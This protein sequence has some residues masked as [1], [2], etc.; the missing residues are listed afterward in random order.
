MVWALPILVA[1]SP[2]AQYVLDTAAADLNGRLSADQISLGWFSPVRL[3]GVALKDPQGQRILD[4]SKAESSSS[5]LSLLMNPSSLGRLRVERPNL[6]LVLRPDGSNLEDL[7]AKL[8]S[9]G[10]SSTDVGIE[11]V[12]GTVSVLDTATQRQ[13]QIS[14]FQGVVTLPG[15]AQKPCEVT[16]SGTIDESGHASRFQVDLEMRQS[17][18]QRSD[19]PLPPHTLKVTTESLPLEMF[20]SVLGRVLS[21][22]I[23]LAGRLTSSVEGTWDGASQGMPFQFRGNV[24]AEQLRLATAAL[25]TDEVQLA[26]LVANG[27]VGWQ[28]GRLQVEQ[29]SAQTDVGSLQASGALALGDSTG[30]LLASLPQQTFQI[31]GQLDLARLAAMLPQTLSIQKDTQIRSGVLRLSLASRR[32]SQGMRWQGRLES[33]RLQAT[34]GGRSVEWE[35]PIRLSFNAHQTSQGPVVEDLTCESSF[36]KANG[37]GT[38]DRL[39]TKA[40]VDLGRL[41]EELRGLV[42]LGDLRMAGDGWAQL[43]WNRTPQQAFHADG[44]LQLR[45]FEFTLPNRPAWKEDSLN[46]WLVATGKTDFTVD[47]RLETAMVRV[48]SGADQLLVNLAQPMANL[49]DGGLWPVGVRAQGQLER[50][51]PRLAPWVNLSDWQFAGSHQLAAD[52]VGSA[53]AVQVQRAQVLLEQLSVAGPGIRILEPRVELTASGTWNRSDE[54]I[55]LPQVALACQSLSAQV[56][57]ATI[58]LP[59]QGAVQMA[60]VVHF[61]GDLDRIQQWITAAQTTPV[62]WRLA[63]QLSGD[64]DLHQS[65]GKTTGNLEAMVYNLAVAH[66]SGQTFQQPAIRIS[67]RADYEPSRGTVHLER[68]E[69]T[70][71]MAKLELAGDIAAAKQTRLDL[72]GQL[73]YDL[74]QISG[75]L[76]ALV[77]SSIRISG[78]GS[79]PI[80]YH[81]PLDL[82][83][84]EGS[85]ALGWTS[86]DVYGFRVGPGTL[87][88]SLGGG[89]VNF[90]PLELDVSEGK[91]RLTP[92]IQFTPEASILSVQSGRLAE[93]VRINAEMCVN[94]LQYIAPALAGVASA[95]GR[96][97]IDLDRL[98]VPLEEPSRGQ[99]AGRMMIHSVQIG[100][101]PLIQE[102]ALAMGYNGPAQLARESTIDFQMVDGRV[103]HRQLELVFPDV[104]VRTQGSVGFDKSLALMAEMPIPRKWQGNNPLGSALRGQS[105]QLPISGTL[106]K[107]KLDRNALEQASRQFLQNATQNVLQDQLNKGLNRLFNAPQQR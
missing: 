17:G 35:Q 39:T 74:D 71:E 83:T 47:T 13:W 91:V 33:S 15:D 7:I 89:A 95:E 5:L 101:G 6:V 61:Q 86:A 20:Q 65:Q 78:R 56:K 93:Q 14:G 21:K 75:L 10:G 50:W 44:Q 82:A 30:T 52:L 55:E 49:R 94:A 12:D 25:G 54:R 18:Y 9:S 1:H 40:T 81:G 41:V 79:S 67:G 84:A 57:Q 24:K 23:R 69:V 80:A 96:F 51:R 103:Y 77:G 106:D 99:S 105:L 100:P 70:A 22:P 8:K 98:Q 72:E 73:H 37:S 16:A 68:A 90:R 76:T 48:E 85:A 32:E 43:N 38:P 42:D 29:F 59:E 53:K 58:A 36:L 62:A 11:V 4:L 2:L 87:Q 92:R 26:Q 104:T 45:N 19:G 88:A 3:S 66:S 28:D 64:L 31:E 60:G 97:S 102:L 107:P 63:G 46:V 34:S 27:K